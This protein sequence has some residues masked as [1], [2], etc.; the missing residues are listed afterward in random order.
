MSLFSELFGVG[1][2]LKSIQRGRIDIPS[3]TSGSATATI[4]A[5]DTS[6]AF[7]LFGGASSGNLVATTAVALTNS[8][9][10]TAYMQSSSTAI[11]V[12]VYW[13]VVEFN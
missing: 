2:G 9:T 13:Q 11:A 4:T 1:G 8:T 12:S 3:S 6:K 7:V 5:V 10:V